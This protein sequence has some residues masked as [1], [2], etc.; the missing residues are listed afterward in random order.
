MNRLS[1]SGVDASVA[2]VARFT[3]AERG[4]ASMMAWRRLGSTRAG[5][6]SL[7]S[8]CSKVVLGR[9]STFTALSPLTA[10]YTSAG[11]VRPGDGVRAAAPTSPVRRSEGSW[12][13]VSTKRK[14]TDARLAACAQYRGLRTKVMERPRV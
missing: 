11:G 4:T 2:P 9:S 5:L 6:A 10:E 1:S 8:N 14:V 13:G 12:A 3:M 7:S